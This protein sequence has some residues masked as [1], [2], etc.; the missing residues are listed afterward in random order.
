MPG[1]TVSSVLTEQRSPK[2]EYVAL[3]WLNPH[4][5]LW[6]DCRDAQPVVLVSAPWMIQAKEQGRWEKRA[7]VEKKTS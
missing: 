5:F 2:G 1:Q 7:A 4:S 3:I 6:R